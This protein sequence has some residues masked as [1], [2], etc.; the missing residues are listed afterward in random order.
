MKHVVV[1]FLALSLLAF[2]ARASAANFRIYRVN[3]EMQLDRIPA[4]HE[5]EP[6]CHNM[7]LRFT[8]YRVAQIGYEYCTVY[9][10]K[11][12]K[13]GSELQ[14]SWKQKENPVTQF[15]QGDRWFLVSDDSHGRKMGSWYCKAPK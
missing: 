15:T 5:D 6:G 14:V 4:F 7:L 3:D 13:A 2:G 9:S 12:C 10:E 11:D 1:A 8:V